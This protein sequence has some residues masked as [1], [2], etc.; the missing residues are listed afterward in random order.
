MPINVQNNPAGQFMTATQAVSDQLVIG[1][2]QLVTEPVVIAS[3]QGVLQRG[4]VVGRV[5]STGKWI[6]SKATA[7]DGSQQVLAILAD[8]ADATSADAPAP[9]YTAGEFNSGLLAYDATWALTALAA[10]LRI[11]NINVRS[12]SPA[13]SAL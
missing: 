9:A 11:V 8:I 5:T 12:I 4:A 7:S 10:A 3:G 1:Y 6:L 13:M 2:Q